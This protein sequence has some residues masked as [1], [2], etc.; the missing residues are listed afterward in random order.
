[1]RSSRATT[2]SR[3]DSPPD[4]LSPASNVTGP[5]TT[6]HQ[7]PKPLLRAS[8]TFYERIV[9]DWWW[10]ELGS[11]L[12]S[13]ACVAA[14]VELLLYYD[15]KKQPNDV[16][17]GINLNAFVS[18]FAAITK[19]AMILPVSEAIGQLKWMWFQKERRLFNFFTFDNASRGPW[20]SLLLLG[21]TRCKH[22]VPIGAGITVLALAFEPF[23][24]QSVSFV[25]KD[26]VQGSGTVSVAASYRPISDLQCPVASEFPWTGRCNWAPY[27]SLG[28]CHR[29]QD[30]SRLLR[31]MCQKKALA[32][33]SGGIGAANPCD[34][35]LNTTFVT[36]M[37]SNSG[38]V[39]TIGLTTMVVNRYVQT[40]SGDVYL[41]STVFR[42]TPNVLLDFYVGYTAGGDAQILRNATPVLHECVFNDLNTAVVLRSPNRDPPT[43]GGA[44][45]DPFTMMAAGKTFS[46][47]TNT[48]RLLSNSISANLPT[49]LMNDTLDS[50]GR[51][52]GRWNFVQ[53]GTHDI[54]VVLDPVTEAMTNQMRTS[55]NNGTDL[56]YGDAWGAEIFAKTQRLRLLL[57]GLLL[58]STLILIST[59]IAQSRK[60]QLPSWKSSALAILLHGLTEEVREQFA[61]GTSQSEVEAVSQKLRVKLM[62]NGAHGRLIP[63]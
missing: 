48:T 23:F 10:W 39:Y 60:R 13:F 42:N 30:V 35:A 59:T 38:S 22:L 47:N 7:L 44:P 27:S 21:T 61:Q 33:G 36:G 4:A 25:T 55:T 20:G 15:G 52:P 17:R 12:I 45:N 26:V 14:I 58:L 28:V 24:Q 62:L 18:V 37:W 19:V 63:T 31:H 2:R 43:F 49:M 41:N 57:P 32:L 11:W 34:Y 3:V 29:C 1:M 50:Q 5:N 51:C 6:N 56:V 53:T 54:N 16:V 40:T 9:T 8:T 46:V